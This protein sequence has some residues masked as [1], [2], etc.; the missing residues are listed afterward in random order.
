MTL[1]NLFMALGATACVGLVAPARADDIQSW[2]MFLIS[3]PVKDRLITWTEVQPRF[4]VDDGGRV[5]QFLLR[6]AVGIRLKNEIDVML[7]YHWQVNTSSPDNTIRENRIY[8]HFAAPLY[9]T[10]NGSKLSGQVRIERRS[11]VDEPD[12]IWRTRA[13]LH[14]HIPL[15]GPGTF[16]PVF[17]SETM[18][19]LNGGNNRSRA[20]FEQQR[21]SAGIYAPLG[22]G[23]SLEATYLHQRLGRPGPDPVIHVASLKLTYKLGG[24]NKKGGPVPAMADL[25]MPPPL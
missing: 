13:Q 6:Q 16:G 2:N 7:G 19:N 25:P 5:G 12:K 1:R 15:N 3:G 18:F 14:L 24:K 22:N 11:F 10:S 23:F 21:T 4:L 8:T 17:A 9:T 20:G